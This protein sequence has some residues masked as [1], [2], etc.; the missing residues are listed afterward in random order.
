MSVAGTKIHV[1][2]NGYCWLIS[3]L[4]TFGIIEKPSFLTQQDTKLIN[5][6]VSKLQTFF[7]AEVQAKRKWA[8]QFDVEMRKKIQRLP[9]LRA[10][11]S[12]AEVLSR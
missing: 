1:A 6:V 8:T 5:M 2:G 7:E 3:F 4:A 12:P 10:G 9:Q 11:A